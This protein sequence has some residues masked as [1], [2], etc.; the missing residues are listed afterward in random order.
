MRANSVV[1]TGSQRGSQS[2]SL[3]VYGCARMCVRVVWVWVWSVRVECVQVVP[4]QKKE[5]P[6][7]CHLFLIQYQHNIAYQT[8]FFLIHQF[9]IYICPTFSIWI[10]MCSSTYGLT[11]LML[12]QWN[13]ACCRK[14]ERHLRCYMWFTIPFY[15]HVL[16]LMHIG[17]FLTIGHQRIYS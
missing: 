13:E 14:I 17:N 15:T 4:N 10:S 7:K 9:D 3:R 8:M 16:V 2:F 12:V 1:H 6:P 5:Q 11:M